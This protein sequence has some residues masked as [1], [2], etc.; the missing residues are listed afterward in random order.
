MKGGQTTF[1]HLE[2]LP[3]VLLEAMGY[4]LPCLVSDTP[5]YREMTREEVEGFLFQ[6]DDFS[7]FVGKLGELLESPEK[8]ENIGENARRKVEKEYNWDEVVRKTEE[9]YQELV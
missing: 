7:N 6:S 2:E 3:I 9:I 4:K 8:L 1:C 5:P